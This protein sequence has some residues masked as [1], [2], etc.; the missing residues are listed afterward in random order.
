MDFIGSAYKGN[1]GIEESQMGS[2]R[3]SLIKSRLKKRG[4]TGAENAFVASRIS[5]GLSTHR[6]ASKYRGF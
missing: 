5:V 1:R 3:E 6:K 4:F 2:T